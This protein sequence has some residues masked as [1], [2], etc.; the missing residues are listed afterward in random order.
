MIAPLRTSAY[1]CFGEFNRVCRS[2]QNEFH[3]GH[4]I[5]VVIPETIDAVGKLI[6]QERQGT[7][8]DLEI[9]TTMYKH[10]FDQHSINIA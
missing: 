6:L 4:P 10:L 9:E 3:E 1:R 5:S 2:L 7:L 8:R